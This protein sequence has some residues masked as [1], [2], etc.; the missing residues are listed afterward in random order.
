MSVTTRKAPERRKVRLGGEKRFLI[1]GMTWQRYATF[2]GWLPE[3]SPIRVAFDGRNM[4]L[5]VTGPKHD[6]L[7]ELLDAFF[8]TVAESLGVL[9]KPQRTTTWIRPEVERG[10]EA[11]CCY[12][13]APAK[14]E[15][16]FAASAAN[17]N[18]VADYPNPDLAMEIDIS[19]PEADRRAIYA[20][21]GV[22]ELW[23][24]DGEDLT[25]ERLGADKRYH[26]VEASGFLPVQ[27]REVEHWLLNED[28]KDQGAWKQR[29]RAW[30]R[31]TLRKR[32]RN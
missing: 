11:D 26:A 13:L 5:M 27:A 25:I 1:P 21:V 10:L 20:A 29:I 12:Y 23:I 2:V 17:S 4:E 15:A 16:A 19:R 3:G 7:A 8:K 28:H 24:F 30:A 6:E 18:D 14:L 9:Y 32:K 22:A 31:K